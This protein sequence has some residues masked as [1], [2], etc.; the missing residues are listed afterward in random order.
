MSEPSMK[1]KMS[2]TELRSEYRR[3]VFQVFNGDE[4]I[5]SYGDMFF[6]QPDAYNPTREYDL[7]HVIENLVDGFESTGGVGGKDLAIWR[8]G[9]ILAVIRQGDDGRVEVTRF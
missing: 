6:M 7:E 8:D 5:C 2:H 1:R 3:R 9:R 4:W